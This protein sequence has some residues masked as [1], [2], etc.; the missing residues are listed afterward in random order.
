[1]IDPDYLYSSIKKKKYVIFLFHGIIEKPYPGIRNYTNKHILKDDFEDLLINFK[2]IGKSLSLDSL[3]THHEEKI[4]LPDFS[5]S[6]TFDDGFENNY[7]IARPILEKL[8]IPATFYVS[9]NLIEENLMTWID[10]IEFCIDT[11]NNKTFY[12]PWSNRPFE[13]SSNKSKINFLDNIRRNIKKNPDICMQK[14]I[15]KYIFNHTG[16]EIIK[17][18][19][20]PLDKKMNW[21][22]VRILH[23]HELFSIGG[24]SHNHQSL[25]LLKPH[26]MRKEIHKSME[27]LAKKGQIQPQHYSYP[28]GQAIDFNNKTISFLKQNGIKCCP[29]AINGIN[30]NRM[31]SLFELKRIIQLWLRLDPSFLTRTQETCFDVRSFGVKSHEVTIM[32]PSIF[33]QSII[34]F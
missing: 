8:S 21:E 12:L 30:S 26:K 5:F 10:Q 13:I 4:P 31:I 28:E 32:L 18:N 11:I 14:K 2:K 19:N 24:H 7:S 15:V 22:Q 33:N 34:Q 29:T 16:I 20:G 6:I 25:G 3:I 1:M 27:Y 9:T 23:N 17:S